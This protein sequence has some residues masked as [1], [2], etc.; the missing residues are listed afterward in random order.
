MATSKL[1]VTKACRLFK[2]STWNKAKLYLP[3]ALSFLPIDIDNK[4]AIMSAISKGN[5]F[6][7]VVPNGVIWTVLY[8]Y[9]W[10]VNEKL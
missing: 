5:T 7:Y 1:F 8:Q 10:F 3:P 4:F 2:S 6:V 9:V